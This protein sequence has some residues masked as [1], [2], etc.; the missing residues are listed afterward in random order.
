MALIS[1]HDTTRKLFESSSKFEEILLQSYHEH[2][3]ARVKQ[4][5]KCTSKQNVF[6]FQNTVS[7]VYLSLVNLRH[8]RRPLT[9]DTN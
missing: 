7:N 6:S 9:N 2:S 5:F 3:V 1:I 8:L 4:T